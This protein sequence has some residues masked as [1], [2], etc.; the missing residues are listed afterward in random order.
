MAR[1]PLKTTSDT[2][3]KLIG[4]EASFDS[5]DL[6]RGIIARIVERTG[7]GSL[8]QD[9]DLNTAQNAQEKIRPVSMRQTL[10]TAP[11]RLRLRG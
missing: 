4:T 2:V 6:E 9:I 7:P 8:Q 10:N 3:L 5:E 11:P 1:E